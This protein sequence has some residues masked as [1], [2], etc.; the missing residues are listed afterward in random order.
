M[1]GGHD[2]FDAGTVFVSLTLFNLLK[3]PLHLL[4]VM[5]TKVREGF[6][7]VNK[8]EEYQNEKKK[9]TL[10]DYSKIFPL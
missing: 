3:M 2:V 8:L 1:E 4:P 9:K 7:S 10:L 6:S 5:I